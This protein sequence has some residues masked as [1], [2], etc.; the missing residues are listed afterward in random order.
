MAVVDSEAV[1]KSRASR[2]GVS[3]DVF[4][5]LVD[6]GLKT[7]GAFA[8]CSSYVPGA[9]DDRAFVETIKRALDRDAEIGEMATLRR[10]FNDS[11]AAAAA[12][13]KA[14]VEQSDENP[15]RKLPAAERSERFEEQKKRL[16]GLNIPGHLEP[17]D[18]L[19]D[20]AVQMYEQDRLRYIE[21]QQCVSREHEV[22]TQ[23]K[24]DPLLSF[25]ASGNLKISKKDQ[26]TPCEASTDL[27]VKYCLSRRGL[28]LEQG[29]VMSYHC[30][31]QWSEHLFRAR[32]KEVPDGYAKVSFKQMQAA[33][34]KLFVALG[35]RT[36]SGLKAVAAGRPCDLAFE[37]VMN[38][39]EVQHL[40]QPMPVSSQTRTRS[41]TPSRKLD[42]GNGKGKDKKKGKEKSTW[43][44]SVPKE[45]LALGCVGSTPK[46]LA[47]CYDFNLGK[48]NR[49]VQRQ[50]CEKGLHLCAVK[51]CFKDHAAMSCT[52]K[53]E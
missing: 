8:F 5:K 1:F 53:L 50:R 39:P 2:I 32:L 20:A 26:I 12:E 31:E 42:K 9:S 7:M 24:R 37:D 52:K 27:Q 51:G 30:H 38:S 49:P 48:C 4:D 40:L 22:L 13:M 29:N 21:W 18:S 6:A 16:K 10:L 41:R 23:S 28:A 33:D 34:A 3:D 11:Y 36:R 35:E 43:S 19:V 47:L 44:P 17:G 15:V 14:V 25:D 45:L 46:G